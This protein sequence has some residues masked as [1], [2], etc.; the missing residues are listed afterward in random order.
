MAGPLPLIP[1]NTPSSYGQE[2]QIQKDIQSA[3]QYNPATKLGI[4]ADAQAKKK[5]P[6]V[7][8]T[9]K[10][11]LGKSPMDV[12]PD[13]IGEPLKSIGTPPKPG[14]APAA[15]PLPSLH[16]HFQRLASLPGA[17]P[18]IQ[19]YAKNLKRS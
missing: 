14:A 5:I 15:L 18:E 3:S 9:T 17:S 16:Q 8:P 19:F 1:E 2:T 12:E 11:V 10:K 4:T 7:T 6:D 13:K